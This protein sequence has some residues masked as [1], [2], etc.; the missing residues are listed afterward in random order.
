MIKAT[1]LT[2]PYLLFGDD[3]NIVTIETGVPSYGIFC[4]DVQDKINL[5]NNDFYETEIKESFQM[6]NGNRLKTISIVNRLYN[7]SL[8]KTHIIETIFP[9]D[10]VFCYDENVYE[11]DPDYFL[12]MFS[13]DGYVIREDVNLG[14]PCSND[15]YIYVS[16]FQWEDHT[17][18]RGDKL[19]ESFMEFCKEYKQYLQGYAYEVWD[20]KEGVSYGFIADDEEHAINLFKK[21]IANESY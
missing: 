5:P 20:T 11:L 19:Q 13:Y 8:F 2:N 3:I 1:S 21:E 9:E 15:Y 6:Q 7:E 18:L 10:K 4:D 17:G 16:K 14:S 12:H